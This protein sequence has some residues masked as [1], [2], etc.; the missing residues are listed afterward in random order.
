MRRSQLKVCESV[1]SSSED[2]PI[3]DLDDNDDDAICY[4]KMIIKVQ[5]NTENQSYTPKS[6]WTICYTM[7]LKR[8]KMNL[9][10][11]EKF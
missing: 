6:F 8:W 4:E 10:I 2:E 11:F 3:N 1:E 7:H 9:Q 5:G